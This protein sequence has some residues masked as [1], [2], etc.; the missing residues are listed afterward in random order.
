MA[1]IIIPTRGDIILCNFSPTLGH[2]QAGLRPAVVLSDSELNKLTHMITICP[3]TNTVRGNPFEIKINNKKTKGVIL[4]HHIRSI[5]FTVRKVKIVDK[6]DTVLLKEV[7]DKI[8]VLI[9][10]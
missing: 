2:E 7:T 4:V 5:D 6:I 8:N 9:E 10:G 3:I 1:T